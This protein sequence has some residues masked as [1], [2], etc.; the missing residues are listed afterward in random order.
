MAVLINIMQIEFLNYSFYIEKKYTWFF[1]KE[2]INENS[3][4]S[5]FFYFIFCFIKI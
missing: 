2:G 5:L 1:T 4:V 3:F